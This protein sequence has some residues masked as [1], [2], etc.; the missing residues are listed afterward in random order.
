MLPF[1]FLLAAARI[2]FSSFPAVPEAFQFLFPTDFLPPE[3]WKKAS[4]GLHHKPAP[5]MNCFQLLHTLFLKPTGTIK[6]FSSRLINVLI[7]RDDQLVLSARVLIISSDAI[8]CDFHISFMIS[9]SASD[10]FGIRILCPFC[11][12]MSF[13]N[14]ILSAKITFVN[15]NT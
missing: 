3:N 11:K 9:H 5:E 8:G 10:M 15:T 12:I 13:T 6:T 1:I 2:V 7:V 4:P 14:V